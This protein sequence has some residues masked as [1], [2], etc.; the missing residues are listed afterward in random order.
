M[1]PKFLILFI[2]VPVI[3]LMLLIQVGARIGLPATLGIIILTA[4]I[5]TRLT[6]AQGA[7]NMQRAQAAMSEGRL[8]HEEVLDGMLII[9]AGVL[10]IIPGLLT[11]TLGC[12]LMIPALR[13]GF[14]KRFGSSFNAGAQFSGTPASNKPAAKFDDDSVIEAEII[15]D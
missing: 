14:R 4:I 11:D 10:L 8:P 5:G 9:L 15:D 2:V 1:F 7:Y 6:K 12:A 3:E 13:T